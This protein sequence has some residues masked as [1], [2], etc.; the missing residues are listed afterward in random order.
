MSD[1]GYLVRFHNQ[2]YSRNAKKSE[3]ENE[4]RLVHEYKN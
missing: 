3:N 1:K 2:C 4:Y